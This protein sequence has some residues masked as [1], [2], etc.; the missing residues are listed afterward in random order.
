MAKLKIHNIEGEE[1]GDFD[2]DDRFLEFSSKAQVVKDYLVALRHNSRQ[3]SANTKGRS[4]LR[5]SNAKPRPQKGSGRSRQGTIKAPHYRGGG[6]VFGPKPKFDHRIRINRKER[7]YAIRSL[8][9]EKVKEEGISLLKLQK[10]ENPKTKRAIQFVEKVGAINKRILFL[11]SSGEKQDLDRRNLY[12]SMRNVPKVQFMP[13]ECMSGYDVIKA[14]N[15]IVIDS[16]IDQL[17]KI[18]GT[19]RL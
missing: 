14:Q 12:L 6:T 2:F 17:I 15:L 13:I 18:F 9:A 4:E 10:M 5:H 7:R 19:P 1:I 3:F 11:S 8:L 16:A